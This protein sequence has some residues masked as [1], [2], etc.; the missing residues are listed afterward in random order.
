MATTLRK[1]S[2]NSKNEQTGQ[3]FRATKPK[4][5][6]LSI[7]RLKICRKPQ[8][9][10]NRWRNRKDSASVAKDFSAAQVPAKISVAVAGDSGITQRKETKVTKP[11]IRS[12]VETLFFVISCSE[13]ALAGQLYPLWHLG[14]RRV[15]AA[16][17]L[18]V[19]EVKHQ[20]DCEPDN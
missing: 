4:Y 17:A 20:P 7:S 15:D 16:V 18:A 19:A 9:P 1:R 12:S 5:C 6:A 10:A 8:L 14:W 3:S 13:S 2:R 11:S